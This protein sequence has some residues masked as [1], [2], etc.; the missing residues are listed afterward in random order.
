[1]RRCIENDAFTFLPSLAH[2]IAKLV[3]LREEIDTGI[4]ASRA[5][6]FIPGRIRA[7]VHR[8]KPRKVVLGSVPRTLE[9]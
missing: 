7:A 4:E 1:M 5:Q 3:Q 9:A 8:D 6:I 2:S